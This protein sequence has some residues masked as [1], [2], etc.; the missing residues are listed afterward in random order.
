[1][2]RLA[3]R[4]HGR[5]GI[6]SVEVKNLRSRRSRPLTGGTAP[7]VATQWPS[8]GTDRIP[9]SL[10]AAAPVAPA[11]GRRTSVDVARSRFTPTALGSPVPKA[12]HTGVP[13][14]KLAGTGDPR[15]TRVRW[16]GRSGDPARWDRTRSPSRPVLWLPGE[17]EKKHEAARVMNVTS[18]RSRGRRDGCPQVHR[19]RQ[20]VQLTFLGRV[21]RCACGAAF[22]GRT[23]AVPPGREA[24]GGR[25]RVRARDRLAGG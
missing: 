13:R 7:R 8:L 5:S 15:G 17:P 12:H 4:S 25:R 22:R 23:R 14:S 16:A 18:E 21:T 19:V 1:M 20:V 2:I 6:V 11:S 3:G 10:S 9:R 24:G